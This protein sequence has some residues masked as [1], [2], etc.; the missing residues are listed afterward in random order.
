M[1][2]N[3]INQ[4]MG[5][6]RSQNTPAGNPS[7]SV[8]VGQKGLSSGLD[9]LIQ[10]GQD[11]KQRR[12]D[13]DVATALA[14]VGDT[15]QMSPTQYQEALFNQLGRIDGVNATQALGL[16][17]QLSK[18]RFDE[19]AYTDKRIDASNLNNYRDAM[20]GRGSYGMTV[21]DYGNAYMLDKH[22]GEYTKVSSAPTGMVNPK[23]ITLKSVTS[24]DANGV[25]RTVQVPFDK[26]TGQPV[27]GGTTAIPDIPEADLIDFI[28]ME[29]GITTADEFNRL[30]PEKQQ[31]IRQSAIQAFTPAV[32]I[33]DG[34]GV[35]MPKKLDKTMQLP[36]GETVYV[37]ASGNPYKNS[38]GQY[39][40][41]K[42][43]EAMKHNNT[44]K[45]M[46][47]TIGQLDNIVARIKANPGSVASIG[48]D[49]GEWVGNNLNDIL[50]APTTD[51]LNRN[52]IAAN[53]GVIAAGLRKGLES[54]VM[55]D[56]DFD[57]YMKLVPDVNDS[58]QEAI[59]KATQL[60]AQI[61]RQYKL[62]NM[63]APAG[64][65]AQYNPNTGEYRYVR[66]N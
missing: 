13:S 32:S 34:V 16:A 25:E 29:Y 60:K 62:P 42:Q 33:S 17:T 49:F 10:V 57:R 31:A 6:M 43:G 63:G 54:G 48:S 24:R 23:H 11:I 53:G 1:A 47:E 36:S 40:V 59:Y 64:Y 52:Q 2:T 37:D 5:G 51:R 20:A 14:T 46:T 38:N 50:K 19:R 27:S 21:D 66:D 28:Q 9:A 3:V 15:S 18:P 7:A 41:Q 61:A 22:T 35:K 56:K 12:I 45:S 4:L 44:V 65:K 30:S 8:L 39:L 26:T 55:T 58:P